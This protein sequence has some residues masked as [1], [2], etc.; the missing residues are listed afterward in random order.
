[1]PVLGPRSHKRD[2]LP[3][4]TGHEALGLSESL[5]R[6]LV[7][8]LLLGVCQACSFKAGV[9]S[10]SL[11]RACAPGLN[12]ACVSQL[13]LIA[14]RSSSSGS[15]W[16]DRVGD[17]TAISQVW[18]LRHAPPDGNSAGTLARFS[19]LFQCLFTLSDIPVQGLRTAMWPFLSQSGFCQGV[20]ELLG[21]GIP[22]LLVSKTLLSCTFGS[23]W[24]TVLW[25]EDPKSQGVRCT[26]VLCRTPCSIP[27]PVKL[28]FWTV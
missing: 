17:F 19:V 13:L 20:R 1:M 22:G 27:D 12:A 6:H 26:H 23:A 10:L 28:C 21:L 2:R 14:H 16:A 7:W 18:N 15:P 24:A 3:C 4:Q 9:P 8:K 11:R 5:Q 25:A